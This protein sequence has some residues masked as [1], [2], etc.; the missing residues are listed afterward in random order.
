M[1]S[2]GEPDFENEAESL[3]TST[4]RTILTEAVSELRA[5]IARRSAWCDVTAEE[6]GNVAGM[7]S[8]VHA[9]LNLRFT[10]DARIQASKVS[11]RASL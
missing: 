11:A 7:V 8:A 10:E 1:L 4:A 6:R 2:K 9:F 3:L 5:R